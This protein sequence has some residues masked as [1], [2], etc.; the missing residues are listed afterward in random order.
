MALMEQK[1]QYEGTVVEVGN[2]R[3]VCP[4]AGLPDAHS[5]FGGEGMV[6][7]ETDGAILVSA[8]PVVKQKCRDVVGAV[9]PNGL[10]C[11]TL[12]KVRT[13]ALCCHSACNFV[14]DV[15]TMPTV[16]QG[17]FPSLNERDFGRSAQHGSVKNHLMKKASFTGVRSIQRAAECFL[18]L[19]GDQNQQ[20]YELNW[21]SLSN[22]FFLMEYSKLGLEHFSLDYPSTTSA[23]PRPPAKR[24]WTPGETGI[25]TARSAPSPR[26]TT[27]STCAALTATLPSSSCNREVSS[28]EPSAAEQSGRFLSSYLTQNSFQLVADAAFIGFGYRREFSQG[29]AGVSKVIDFDLACKHIVQCDYVLQGSFQENR[30]GLHPKRSD[31]YAADLRARSWPGSASQRHNH[32]PVVGCREVSSFYQTTLQTFGVANRRRRST[33]NPIQ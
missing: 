33:V 15:G 32:Q 10:Y 20:G 11:A 23:S 3:G 24:S 26:Y 7:V 2:S 25:K 30:A 13:R 5:K 27:A 28:S 9:E 21:L 8:R 29:M 19:P 6:T 12:Q 18:D 16:Q 14:V 17:L 31:T 22:G 1:E 4:S